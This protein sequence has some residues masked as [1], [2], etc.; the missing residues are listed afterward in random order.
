[1]V[2]LI[3]LTTLDYRAFRELQKS[4]KIEIVS[5]ILQEKAS[6]HKQKKS[7]SP[8][9]A[10]KVRAKPED[11][12]LQ[13]GEAWQSEETCKHADGE[14][15]QVIKGLRI[16]TVFGFFWFILLKVQVIEFCLKIAQATAK[17][18]TVE[19]KWRVISPSDLLMSVSFLFLERNSV[20]FN[21]RFCLY[22]MF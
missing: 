18:E 4:R 7:Q 8:T 3:F 14:I 19:N 16:L 2:G 1:M 17:H 13:R 21:I 12:L 11:P 9:K 15:S 10:I 6:I 5:R 22:L 20:T